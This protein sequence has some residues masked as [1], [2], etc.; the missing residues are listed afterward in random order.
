MPRI[1]T[2][3][4]E[5]LDDDKTASLPSREWRAFVSL[6][7]LADDR[8]HVRANPRWLVGQI[9]WADPSHVDIHEVL[10]RLS[11]DTLIILYAHAGQP[12]LKVKSWEKHQKVDHPSQPRMPQLEDDDGSFDWDKALGTSLFPLDSRPPREVVAL[13]LG[14]RTKDLGS[15][16]KDQEP[17]SRVSA[18]SFGESGSGL[19]ASMPDLEIAVNTW[20]WNVSEIQKSKV[21]GRAHRVIGAGGIEPHEWRYAKK[22]TEEQILAGDKSRRVAY[23]LGVVEK[24]R[25]V[26]EQEKNRPSPPPRPQKA[27]GRPTMAEL[28]AYMDAKEKREAEECAAAGHPKDSCE[29]EPEPAEAGT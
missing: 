13:D 5:I 9:F 11:R 24:E 20:R 3:K 21:K 7:T 23:F 10:A 6:I 15:R 8:G 14:P 2:L 18:D 1:R 22:T 29:C 26:A 19:I 28:D 25:E 27:G 12:Y 4:P 16:I 17:A